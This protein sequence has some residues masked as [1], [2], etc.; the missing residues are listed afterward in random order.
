MRFRNRS[1]AGRLLARRLAAYAGRPDGVVLGLARGGVPGAGRVA[2]TL[3]APLDVFV[4]RK[5]GVPWDEELAMGAI[6]SGGIR[7]LN[8]AVLEPLGITVDMLARVMEREAKELDRRERTYRGGRAPL[9]V[10]GK[11]VIL[12]DDGLA[13]G[14]SLRAAIEALR[15][16]HAARIVGAPPVAAPAACAELA[17]IADDIVCAI[18]PEPFRGVGFWYDDFSQTSDDEV[19]AAPTHAATARAGP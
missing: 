2:I 13:T 10:R 6:A 1:D 17:R 9:D 11:P 19:R 5:L 7:V 3:G 18:T 12:V 16:R 14:A 15:V 4:V 8:R